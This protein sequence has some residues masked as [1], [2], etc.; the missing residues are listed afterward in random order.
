MVASF[1]G[2]LGKSTDSS[3]LQTSIVPDATPL[4]ENVAV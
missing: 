1:I 4:R 3:F 2:G